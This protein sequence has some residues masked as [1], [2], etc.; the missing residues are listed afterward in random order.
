LVSYC[1]SGLS[2]RDVTRITMHFYSERMRRL[3]ASNLLPQRAGQ[4]VWAL[5]HIGFPDLCALDKD[6]ALQDRWI[7]EYRARWAAQ[8]A[9]ASA[10]PSDGGAWLEGD[11]MI[12]PVVTADLDPAPSS[13][14][15]PCACSTTGSAATPAGTPTALRAP[16]TAGTPAVT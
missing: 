7:T 10:G 16:R 4:P 12:I 15:L 8:R 2:A 11:A 1:G 14:S 13:R 3:L 6:S 5:V 9:A